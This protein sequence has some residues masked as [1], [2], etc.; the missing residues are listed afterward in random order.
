MCQSNT[1]LRKFAELTISDETAPLRRHLITIP[2]RQVNISSELP[3]KRGIV[4][5]LNVLLDSL[6]PDVWMSEARR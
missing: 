4:S 6:V 3:T 5:S 2:E 1:C